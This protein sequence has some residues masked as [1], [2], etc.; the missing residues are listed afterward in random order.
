MTK[1]AQI[2]R[3]RLDSFIRSLNGQIFTVEFVKKD[4]STR[5]MNARRGV[6]LGV[7]GKGSPN[8]LNTT[9]VKVF[10]MKANGFRQINLATVNYI[11]SGG[12]KFMVTG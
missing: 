5:V 3:V 9:A 8:G 11:K 1:I 4:G 2:N 6:K 7:T 12:V 10:D